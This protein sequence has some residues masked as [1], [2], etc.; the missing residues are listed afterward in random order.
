MGG[1]GAGVQA[2]NFGKKDFEFGFG[3]DGLQDTSRHFKGSFGSIRAILPWEA[4]EQKL[5]QKPESEL[6]V[7]E[8]SYCHHSICLEKTII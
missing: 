4:S 2:F 5:G 7:I 1:G 8:L 6:K 3:G